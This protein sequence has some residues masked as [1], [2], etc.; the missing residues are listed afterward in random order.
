M[1]LQK[2][3]SRFLSKDDIIAFSL[4]FSQALCIVNKFDISKVHVTALLYKALPHITLDVDL[5]MNHKISQNN[6]CKFVTEIFS[7]RLLKTS[8]YNIEIQLDF[9][10]L[11]H[12][13]DF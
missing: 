1:I 6:F 2:R 13:P 8:L 10:S 9:K 4:Y 7:R 5:F 11:P 3:D 12:N